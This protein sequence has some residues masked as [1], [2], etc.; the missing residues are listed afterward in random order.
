MSYILIVR[1]YNWKLPRDSI[2]KDGVKTTGVDVVGP[3]NLDIEFS[4]IY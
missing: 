4:K 3:S 2:H 1:K